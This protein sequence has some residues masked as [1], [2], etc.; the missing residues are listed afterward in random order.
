MSLGQ[1]SGIRERSDDIDQEIQHVAYCDVYEDSLFGLPANCSYPPE[2]QQKEDNYANY[3]CFA[4]EKCIV[5]LHN[6][7]IAR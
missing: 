2:K 4:I 1:I 7:I 3:V 6:A 5:S